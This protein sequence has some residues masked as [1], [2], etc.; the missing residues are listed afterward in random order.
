MPRCQISSKSLR[1]EPTCSARTDRHDEASSRFSQL[2]SKQILC[3]MRLVSRRHK[4]LSWARPLYFTCSH[5]ICLR[6][7]LSVISDEKF[8]HSFTLA[9]KIA[10]LFLVYSMRAT[11]PSHLALLH[12]IG[13]GYLGNKWNLDAL[14]QLSSLFWSFFL[15]SKTNYCSLTSIRWTNHYSF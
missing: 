7:F 1:W 8:S 9:I 2:A 4:I 14:P 6:P 10:Q 5:H 11:Y 13:L 3:F 12:L 15:S